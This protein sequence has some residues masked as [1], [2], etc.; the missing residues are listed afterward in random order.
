MVGS[1]RIISFPS[2]PNHRNIGGS[3]YALLWESY[4]ICHGK[5]VTGLFSVYK[6]M[7]L[8]LAQH[9]NHKNMLCSIPVFVI[10]PR[11]WNFLTGPRDQL[12]L[13][14]PPSY[15]IPALNYWQ[16]DTVCTNVSPSVDVWLSSTDSQL[17]LRGGVC[18]H[19]VPK[20]VIT[21]SHYPF[22][23]TL[24]PV[25]ISCRTVKL[26]LCVC[27]QKRGRPAEGFTH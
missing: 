8:C 19:L 11:V 9:C 10:S 1:L 21:K 3:L 26:P 25:I 4:D 24:L 22:I 5:E 20:T 18:W 12:E 13:F 23:N 6:N 7:F 27:S 15:L 17:I 2:S 16:D 14:S